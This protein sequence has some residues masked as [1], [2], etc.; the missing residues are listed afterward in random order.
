MLSAFALAF[1]QI[2]DRAFLKVLVKS[3]LLT[4]LLFG[5]VAGAAGWL[6]A[7]VDPC[8][9]PWIGGRCRLG[10]GGGTVAALLLG[11][12]ALVFLFPAIAIGVIG[13][14]SDE[15][16]EAVEARHYPGARG[17][18]VP[19]PRS[20]ALSARSVARLLLWNLIALPFYVLLLITGLGP[21]LLFSAVNSL[22]LGRDL[23]EMVAARHLDGAAFD[24]WLKR[25]R[26]QRALL[27]LGATWLFLIPFAN[28]LAPL[29]GAAAATHMF[30]KG[31]R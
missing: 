31:K 4:L 30:H 27:G 2:G 6:L 19:L 20:L 25:T 23:G 14:F 17:R 1:G 22:A 26:P 5:L 7:G 8:A 15:I 29:L 9:N 28:L 12:A 16:V 18:P 21:L 10:A 13:I 3:L 24:A 11:G